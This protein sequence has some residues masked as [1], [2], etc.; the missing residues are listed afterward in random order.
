MPELPEVECLTRAVRLVLEGARLET[1]EFLRADLRSPIPIAQ[2]RQLFEGQLIEQVF[3]RSKYMLIR[4]AK[5]TGVFHL[6]M[7][8]QILEKDSA[9]PDVPHTHAVFK[10]QGRG[11][12]TYLHFVDPRRFGR[13]DCFEGHAVERNAYFEHLGPE[14]L[15]CADLGEHLFRQSR[16]KATAV[17]QFIMDAQQVV[18]VG[19]IYASESLFRAGIH[20]KRKAG[21]VSRQ[22]YDKLGEQ[23]KLTL[24]AAIT[25]GGTT[26]RDF[27][28][29]DG[30]PG[31]FAVS[32]NVY[33]RAGE[34][35]LRCGGEIRQIRQGGRSSFFCAF[36]QT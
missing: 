4:S 14:P 1:A 12:R 24:E 22:R 32:L 11:G 36:C 26:L 33:D 2:F 27:R 21:A 19:N 20:P 8:G 9:K 6:G 18:G 13:I 23:I 31:Y 34:P 17:K 25:A 35:C 7:T 5:G 16:H 29:P 10:V 3:R 15:D 28:T 30:L